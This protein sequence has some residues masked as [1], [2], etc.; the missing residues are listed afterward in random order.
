MRR[1]RLK[2]ASQKRGIVVSAKATPTSAAPVIWMATSPTGERVVK[3]S[4]TTT[5]ASSAAPKRPR[6]EKRSRGYIAPEPN[7]PASARDP[8]PRVEE[9]ELDRGRRGPGPSF[10]CE[11]IDGELERLPRPLPRLDRVAHVARLVVGDDGALGC[12]VDAIEA[13]IHAAAV[14]R[15]AEALF[16][17]AR[18][19][20]AGHQLRGAEA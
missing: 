5:H 8:T 4:A 3:S 9:V 7:G 1:W 10:V 19:G 20:R 17:A 2:A 18:R 14:E 11:R 6:L 15:E 13:P 12:L 16:D